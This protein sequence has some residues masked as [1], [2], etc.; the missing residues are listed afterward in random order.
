MLTGESVPVSKVP[1]KDDDL[2]RWRDIKDENPK[3]FLY[4]GTRVVRI[5]GAL[6]ADGSQGR[7]SLG[8]VVRTSKP[9]P[10]AMP[11]TLC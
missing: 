4:A 9:G 3:S 1:I 5:R 11:Q 8:M 2:A 10:F 7:P 6:A